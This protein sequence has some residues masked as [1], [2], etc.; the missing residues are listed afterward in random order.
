MINVD[1]QFVIHNPTTVFF[2]LS[3][4]LLAPPSTTNGW[5]HASK[6]ENHL[7]AA[8]RMK[9]PR[10][11]FAAQLR[12]FISILS[13]FFYYMTYLVRLREENR[14]RMVMT[15]RPP[16]H[17]VANSSSNARMNRGGSRQVASRASYFF[18]GVS[19]FCG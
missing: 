15:T 1:L 8:M 4:F 6:P 5:L 11:R 14:A 12:Y 13:S 9:G 2:P 17:T 19:F 3:T 10:W 16:Q 18:W 7:W